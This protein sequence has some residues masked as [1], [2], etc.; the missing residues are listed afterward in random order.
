MVHRDT[1]QKCRRCFAKMPSMAR[2]GTFPLRRVDR[3]RELEDNYWM[4]VAEVGVMW[5]IGWK[6]EQW[7]KRERAWKGVG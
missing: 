6:L 5:E 3:I 7:E 4:C 2:Q 1:R